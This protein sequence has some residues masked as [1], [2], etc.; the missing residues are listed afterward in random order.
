MDIVKLETAMC[1]PD[2]RFIKYLFVYYSTNKR[3]IN[4]FVNYVSE[5]VYWWFIFEWRSRTWYTEN[6]RYF[7][8]IFFDVIYRL[9]THMPLG[10]ISKLHTHHGGRQKLSLYHKAE[11]V[12]WQMILDYFKISKEEMNNSITLKP[13]K[14]CSLEGPEK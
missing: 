2:V 10:G 3:N 8:K 13:G 4:S 6:T 9:T 11:N 7:S 5:N 14:W 12:S 1:K